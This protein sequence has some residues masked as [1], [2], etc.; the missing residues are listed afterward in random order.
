MLLPCFTTPRHHSSCHLS[1]Q[2]R[3]ASRSTFLLHLHQQPLLPRAPAS[4][5]SA[6]LANRPTESDRQT[7]K[8]RRKHATSTGSPA[9][10]VSAAAA[11]AFALPSFPENT[12]FPARNTY[13][14][15][16]WREV[17]RSESFFITLETAISKSSCVTC[18]R[19]SRSANM[20]ASVHTA[21]A[22]HDALQHA[23]VRLQ[24]VRVQGKATDRDTRSVRWRA[25]PQAST[26][27][28]CATRKRHRQPAAT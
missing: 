17:S 11:S 20:P 15:N 5:P 19:R 1:A 8:D 10:E 4:R 9:L 23:S 7:D 6:K 25:P 12:Y 3:R 26:T 21:C 22:H 2:R 16:F 28:T 14:Q 27:E 24:R 13:F 18:T